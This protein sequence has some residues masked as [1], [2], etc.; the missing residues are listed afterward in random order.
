MARNARKK[1][2]KKSKKSILKHVKEAEKVSSEAIGKEMDDELERIEKK[3]EVWQKKNVE[4]HSMQ[5][6]AAR[7]LKFIKRTG[8]ITSVDHAIFQHEMGRIHLLEMDMVGS[9]DRSGDK[10]NLELARSKANELLHKVF[11]SGASDRLERSL[12]GTTWRYGQSY[13]MDTSV[14]T[15][16]INNLLNFDCKSWFR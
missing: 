16:G 13:D 5:R 4:P 1:N 14:F 11:D 6:F 12:E 9:L 10:T 2:D 15:S 3:M 8:V 7:I